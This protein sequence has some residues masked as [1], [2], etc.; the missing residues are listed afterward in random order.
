[1]PIGGERAFLWAR[2][3]WFSGAPDGVSN[4]CAIEA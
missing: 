2:E 4:I 1:M 3:M